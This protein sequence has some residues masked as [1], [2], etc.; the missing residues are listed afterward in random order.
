MITGSDNVLT[1][2]AT[3]RV[4]EGGEITEMKAVKKE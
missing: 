2:W 3:G 1:Q 4:K